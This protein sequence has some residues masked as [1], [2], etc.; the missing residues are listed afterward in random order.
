M[1]VKQMS[2]DQLRNDLVS[3]SLTWP[4]GIP[5]QQNDRVNALKAELKRRGEPLEPLAGRAASPPVSLK[6][7]TDNELEVELRTLSMRNDEESQ[8]RFADVRFELRQRAQ[9]GD[10]VEPPPRAQVAPRALEL[11]SDEEAERA[12]PRRQPEAS[13]TNVKLV[14]RVLT[15]VGGFSVTSQDDGNVLVKYDAISMSG[16]VHVER[17]LNANEV[18]M[19]V[20]MLVNSMSSKKD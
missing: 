2:A 6:S 3:I 20:A 18:G 1:S 9:V 12:M 13:Q 16:G 17:T 4:D 14:K 15:S 11:P 5:W 7:M 10:K 8:K 19:L